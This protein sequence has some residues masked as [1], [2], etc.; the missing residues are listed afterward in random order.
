[1]KNIKNHPRLI[2]RNTL[3][4]LGISSILAACSASNQLESNND[5]KAK[6]D[7]NHRAN[8][9]MQTVDEMPPIP[10]QELRK[11][12]GR[13]QAPE[14][15]TMQ[16]MTP[17][18]SPAAPP[19]VYIPPSELMVTSS[20]TESYAPALR[21]APKI[22]VQTSAQDTAKYQSYQENSWKR[23]TEDP[24]STFSADVDTGSYANVRRFIQQGQLPHPDAVRAEELVNYFSYD[25]ALPNKND[26]HP[27]SVNTQLTVS[28]WNAKRQ[29]LRIA[30]KGKDIAKESLPAANLVF[31]VDVSGSMSPPDRLPLVKSALKLLTAQL[32]AQDRVSLVTYANGTQVVLTPTPGNQ[33]DKINLA[34]DQLSAGGGTNGEAGIKLAY[35]QAHAAKIKDSKDSINRVLLATD[36]DLNIGITNDRDLKSLVERERKA[37]IS[38]ST[39]GVGDSN[40]NEALMKKLADNGDGSYHYLDSLQEAHKVLVNEYTSSLATIAQDLKL[41]LEFNPALVKEYRLIGYELRALAREQFNDDKV[42]AGDIGSGHTVTAL[43]EIVSQGSKGN[44]DPLRYQADK[45]IQGNSKQ[46]LGWLKLRYKTPGSSQSQ[47]IETPIQQASLSPNILAADQDFRFATAVAAWAQWLRGS[48]LIENFGPKEI[49]ALANSA[50]ANDRFGHRAEFVRLVELSSALHHAQGARENLNSDGQANE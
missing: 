20:K 25:Y 9:V 50:R 5:A 16:I 29:L 41:Q 42:D 18:P 3:L 28:P 4:I 14:Y 36:G 23:V 44:V 26:A 21:E 22:S 43:Y 10:Q 46:E 2:Q 8:L 40:Y 15:R 48:S 31:L 24:V 35:A 45:A 34:I 47:L 11:S 39:L 19:A 38:L 33:K 49:L 13:Q 17:S 6:A 1:M 27:F 7:A 30:I 12:A 37:G 32:R